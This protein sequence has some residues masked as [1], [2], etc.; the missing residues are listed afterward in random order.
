MDKTENYIQ[1]LTSD[2][3][4]QRISQGYVNTTIDSG[5]KTTKQIIKDNLLTYFNAIFLLLAFFVCVAGSFRSLTFLP[6]VIGN[7]LIGIIQEIRA[8]NIIEKMSI[9][10]APHAVVIRNGIEQKITSDLL[11][12]DDLIIFQAGDQIPVDAKVI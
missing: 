12:K 4:N 10:N 11:V 3:V 7:T 2:Q 6:V 5:A 1:G 8:R 9:L